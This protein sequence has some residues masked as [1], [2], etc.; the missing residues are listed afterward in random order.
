MNK[1]EKSEFEKFIFKIE[2]H[3]KTGKYQKVLAFSEKR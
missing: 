3:Y 2:K 1:F